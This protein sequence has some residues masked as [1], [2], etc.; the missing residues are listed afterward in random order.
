VTHPVQLCLFCWRTP[1]IDE[2][3]SYP[4]EG[5]SYYSMG[6]PGWVEPCPCQYDPLERE[7]T[8]LP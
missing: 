5:P 8:G 4:A 3:R 1:G 6:E 2:E 7:E